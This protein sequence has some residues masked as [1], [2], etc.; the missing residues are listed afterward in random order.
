MYSVQKSAVRRDVKLLLRQLS[1]EEI[2]AKSE[3][4]WQQVEQL[5]EFRRASVLLLYSALPDEVQTQDFIQRHSKRLRALL[6][7]MHGDTLLVGE[8]I[9]A[10][11]I[12][13]F[14]VLEPA[15]A[16][17]KIPPIDAAIIPGVAFDRH[18]NRLGRGKGYYDKLL[19]AIATHK[20]GVC[21]GCQLLELVPHD[22]H[23]VKM[24]KVVWA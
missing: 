20:I 22:A 11:R 17:S 3:A 1:P 14:G 2:A 6:P 10:K 23:D 9:G 5:E 12:A 4:V 13:R 15:Q 24:D 16:L 7:V 8:A 21:F 18:N 19:S